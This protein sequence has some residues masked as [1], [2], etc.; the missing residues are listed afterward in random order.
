MY[1]CNPENADLGAIRAATVCELVS[2]DHGAVAMAMLPPG[3]AWHLGFGAHLRTAS[4]LQL[5]LFRLRSVALPL[6]T[7][8]MPHPIT[9]YIRLKLQL[10]LLLSCQPQRPSIRVSQCL[11]ALSQV[12][13][14][15]DGSHS[16]CID[17]QHWWNAK[18]AAL[19]VADFQTS[20]NTALPPPHPSLSDVQKKKKKSVER[21]ERW[22]ANKRYVHH[23]AR[24]ITWH[25]G[26]RDFFSFSLAGKET[27][28]RQYMP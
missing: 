21:L 20:L 10:Y 11:N 8:F 2:G 28:R 4:K 9:G 15:T 12:S 5:C 22:C 24:P 1:Y 14:R 17:I 26:S 7:G 23:M 19:S 13:G 27:R 3:W 6:S 18:D 25:A 16:V